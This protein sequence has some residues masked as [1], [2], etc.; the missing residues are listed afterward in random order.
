MDFALFRIEG[1]II[2]RLQGA[3]SVEMALLHRYSA[4]VSLPKTKPK[5]PIVSGWDSHHA[6]LQAVLVHQ[7]E[8][9]EEWVANRRIVE[10]QAQSQA[11]HDEDPDMEG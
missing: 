3:D 1:S 9:G 8:T 5:H 7:H 10:E 4:Q 11:Y 2:I 6:L